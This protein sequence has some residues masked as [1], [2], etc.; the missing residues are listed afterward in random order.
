VLCAE[1]R[2]PGM[3]EDEVG[4]GDGPNVWGVAL[5]RSL[6]AT[7]PRSASEQAAYSKY[8]DERL[9]ARMRVPTARTAPRG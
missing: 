2:A 9:I 1:R 7:G 8:L 6:R 5:F 4:L 3:A